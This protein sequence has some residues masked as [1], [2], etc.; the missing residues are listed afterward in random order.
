VV[1]LVVVTRRAGGPGHTG[2]VRRRDPRVRR[3]RWW[4]RAATRR[5]VGG[6]CRRTGH[7]SIR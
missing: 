4:R 2:G 3:T 7:S 1:R 5:P 6:G